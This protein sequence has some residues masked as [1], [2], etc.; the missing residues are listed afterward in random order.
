MIRLIAVGKVQPK[1]SID[2]HHSR[3]GIGFEKLDRDV[4]EPEKAYPFLAESGVKY[5]RIQSGWQRTEKEKGVYDFTWIDSIVDKLIAIGI[6]PWVCLCYGNP[7]YTEEAK[8]HFGAV[9]CPPIKT[10]AERTAWYNYVKATTAHFNG[11]VHYYE[12]WNEP[13]GVWCWKHGPNAHELAAFTIATAKACKAGDSTCEVLGLATCH[14][15]LAPQ[16]RTAADI[17]AEAQFA[18]LKTYAEDGA[19]D[20]VDGITYHA[21]GPTEET[22]LKRFRAYDY[23][24]QQYCPSA[25][26]VQGETGTQSQY[27]SAGALK[28]ANWTPL[29]QAKFLLRHLLVELSTDCTFVSHFTCMDMIEALNG[30]VGNKASYLDFGYFGVVGAQF[31]ENGRATGEYYAKLSFTALQTL[32]SI[33]CND[34]ESIDFPARGEVRPSRFVIGEDADFNQTIHYAYQKPNGAR[35]LVYWMP[36]NI[37]TE[38]YESTVS[39]RFDELIDLNDVRLVDLLTGTVYAIPEELFVDN[40]LVN[41]PVTDSP[42]LLMFGDFLA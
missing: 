26:I 29:K 33:F 42:L 36:K 16:D 17:D 20:Y 2:I 7:L 34:Y 11:R 23:L 25:K 8:I 24:R 39:L 30:T 4:F 13:D 37:I 32:C 9:G 38:T 40:T 35:G 22:W 10:E 12:V 18:F 28:L 5:A 14:G 41:I 27:S 21:Y 19:F 3:V 15:Y 6:E 1:R 31:D